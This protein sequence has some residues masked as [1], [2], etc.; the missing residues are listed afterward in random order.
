MVNDSILGVE[1]ENW[2]ERS[3]LGRLVAEVEKS[4]RLT[5]GCIGGSL[6]VGA[7]ASDP[8]VHS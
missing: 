7:D 2:I 5:V 1:T 3:G 8:E 4:G 6:T